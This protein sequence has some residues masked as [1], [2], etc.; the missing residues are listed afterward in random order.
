MG[1]GLGLAAAAAAGKGFWY[2]FGSYAGAAVVEF[3]RFPLPFFWLGAGPASAAAL[4]G[5]ML[6][7]RHR[8]G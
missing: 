1:L 3:V 5:R 2:W 6:E 8:C 4:R 7:R